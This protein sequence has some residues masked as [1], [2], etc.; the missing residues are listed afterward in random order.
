MRIFGGLTDCECGCDI[1]KKPTQGGPKSGGVVSE[2][3]AADAC[4]G[5]E[6]DDCCKEEDEPAK[7]S[8]WGKYLD[9]LGKATGGVP[10]TCC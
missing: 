10:P 9:R 5:G 3:L 1:P 7:Q 2:N 8:W 6:K 4:C